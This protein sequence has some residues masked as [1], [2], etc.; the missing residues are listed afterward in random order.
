MGLPQDALKRIN[1][2]HIDL[3]IV[4]PALNEETVILP[5]L[6]RIP[7]KEI[8]KKG[9]TC[10]VIVVDNDS[11]DQTGTIA[12]HWGAKVVL[13]PNRG[14]GNAYRRGFSEAKG[15]LIVMFD[16][17]GTYPVE[18]IIH[19]IQVIRAGKADVVMGSRLKGTIMPGAMSFVLSM[20]PP[21]GPR[22]VL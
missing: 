9:L 11:D 20:K 3:S 12:N 8:Q 17:D 18:D 4:I 19:F 21:R 16:A 14:Y 1:N 6:N 22:S 7:V 5:T 13:E 10:E 2:P 15:D